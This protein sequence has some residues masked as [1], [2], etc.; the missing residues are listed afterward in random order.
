MHALLNR[1]TRGIVAVRNNGPELTAIINQLDSGFQAFKDRHDRRLSQVEAALDEINSG[2]AA[3]RVGGSGEGAPISAA[4]RRRAIQNLGKFAR[5]GRPED[6]REGFQ[7]N[8]SMSSD[9]DT[10]G[11]YTVPEEL[12]GELLTIQRNDSVMRRLARVVQTSSGT[13]KQPMSLAGMDSGWV[14]E[15]QSRA[16]TDASTLAMLEYPAMEIYANPAITQSL[17]DDS[18]Y[19]LGA[20]IASE[21]GDEFTAQEGAAFISG[22]GVNKPR[23]FLSYDTSAVADKTGTRPFGTIQYIAT[24]QASTL[25]TEDPGDQLIDVVYALKAKHRQNATW[26][27]N[28]TT[29]AL[30]RKFK[31]DQDNYLWVEGIQAGQP[32]RLLGYPVEIDEDMSD[33]GTNAYPI[34]FGDWK[35]GYL[36]ADRVGIRILRDNLTNK[37]FVH[38]YAT[39]RVGGGLLDSNAIKLLKCASS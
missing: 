30:V 32:D 18:A 9:N 31:D 16:E 24:G 39:K 26:L 36:I 14:G 12:S 27:M 25:A 11:G 8:A 7:V 5:T 6:L 33:I 1:P 10:N 2:V 37:P 34:A 29:A 20:Y 38:F 22:N 23:G 21:I 15:R 13:F 19:D 17:L 4:S 28:S 35:R 3:L